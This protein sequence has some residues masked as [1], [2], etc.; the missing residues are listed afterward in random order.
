[1]WRNEQ[2]A[3]PAFFWRDDDLSNWVPNVDLC[4]QLAEQRGIGVAFAAI[5][6]RL[7]QR[8]AEAIRNSARSRLA[9]HGYAHDDHAKN[10]DAS[11]FPRLRPTDAVLTEL[12]AGLSLLR[13]KGRSRHL[14]MF[15]PPWGRFDLDYDALLRKSGFVCF[16]GNSKAKRFSLPLQWDCQITTE[17]SRASLDSAAIFAQVANQLQLRRTGKIPR[18]QPL[19]LMTH[20]RTLDAGLVASLEELLD[21]LLEAGF[22]FSDFS[23]IDAVAEQHA[24][25]SVALSPSPTASHGAHAEPGSNEA[26]IAQLTAPTLPRDGEGYPGLARL[27][28]MLAGLSPIALLRF[29]HMQALASRLPSGARVLSV[30]CGKAITEVA[31]A[32]S[33]PDHHWVAFDV[34]PA[35]YGSMQAFAE[36]KDVS[37]ITFLQLDVEAPSAPDTGLGALGTFDA[38]VLV[39]VL[40]YLRDP[41]AALAK[42]SRSLRPGGVLACIEPFVADPQDVKALQALRTHTQSLHGGFTHEALRGFVACAGCLELERI[43]NC[44]QAKPHA[45]VSTLWPQLA[46]SSDPAFV[47]L[48]Y[49]AARL[50]LDGAL[51]TSRREATA[52]A[53]LARAR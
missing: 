29:V 8:A 40:M 17:H 18:Q 44:Y 41:A 30:G 15:V 52:V 39:E 20:H 11:E 28:T 24:P 49:A 46:K 1:M 51:A 53:I 36:E 12:R 10:G 43:Y 7:T 33:F 42:L 31:L 9:V 6:T 50:D 27:L 34:D 21:N 16:S 35:R 4:L 45:L 5:P 26:A 2:A 23:E 14:N 32:M 3:L 48:A 47:D 37:N 25:V 19:G 13:H 38:A 22:A